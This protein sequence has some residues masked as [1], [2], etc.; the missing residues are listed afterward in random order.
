VTILSFAIEAPSGNNLTTAHEVRYGWE[1]WQAGEPTPVSFSYAG[2]SNLASG[3]VD[4]R[5]YL[6]PEPPVNALFGILVTDA[7]G[8]QRFILTDPVSITFALP[9]PTPTPSPTPTPTF[10]PVPTPIQPPTP[11]PTPPATPT[12]TPTP[13]PKPTSIAPPTDIPTASPTKPSTGVDGD[14]D[15]DGIVKLADLQE[16]INSVVHRALVSS[17]ENADING[18]GV[19]DLT[20]LAF[21]IAQITGK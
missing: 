13:S 1:F 8:D 9:T 5:W 15:N 7:K 21:V 14:A 20:D 19:V 6:P 18:N 17:L 4:Y 16:M 3:T 11:T 12:P 10:A 2:D